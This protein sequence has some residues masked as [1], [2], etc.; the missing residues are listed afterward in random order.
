[1]S[2]LYD[3]S[4]YRDLAIRS[5]LLHI[6]SQVTAATHSVSGQWV[7]SVVWLLVELIGKLRSRVCG[8]GDWVWCTSISDLSQV[9]GCGL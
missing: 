7:W 3:C 5:L 8:C 2:V 4:Q 9:G 6:L 1:M